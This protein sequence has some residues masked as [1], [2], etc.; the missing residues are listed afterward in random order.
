MPGGKLKIGS[1]RKKKRPPPPPPPR[2]AHQKDHSIEPTQSPTPKQL[3]KQKLVSDFE[4]K[5]IILK[6]IKDISIK[7]VTKSI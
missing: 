1:A 5:K 3:K 4:T 2:T 7:F 6:D